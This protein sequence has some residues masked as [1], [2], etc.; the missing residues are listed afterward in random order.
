M[1]TRHLAQSMMAVEAA[2]DGVFG[3]MSRPFSGG[4]IDRRQ[5]TWRAPL[6]AQMYHA[7]L[8]PSP[9]GHFYAKPI[10]II[11]S[12]SQAGRWPKLS[13]LLSAD[14]PL[15]GMIAVIGAIGDEEAPDDGR[16]R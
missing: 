6:A 2:A 15:I 12:H 1:T 4:M 10:S 7:Y 9:Q 16:C 11:A 8:F 14:R 3:V 5:S 13:R